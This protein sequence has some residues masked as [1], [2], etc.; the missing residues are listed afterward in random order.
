MFVDPASMLFS[1]SSFNAAVKIAQTHKERVGARV[2]RQGLLVA[3]PA[4]ELEA[5][6]AAL[7]DVLTDGSLARLLRRRPRLV[8]H[9]RR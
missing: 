4:A 2:D 7:L 3:P 8:E 1:I 9:R 6:P 5:Q